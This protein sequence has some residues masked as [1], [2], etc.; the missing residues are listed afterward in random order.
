MK[1]PVFMVFLGVAGLS[2]ISAQRHHPKG[3]RHHKPNRRYQ[4]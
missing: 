3:C 4:P 1:K 2:A